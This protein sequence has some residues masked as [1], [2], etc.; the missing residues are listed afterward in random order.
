MWILGRVTELVNAIA[1]EIWNLLS[2]LLQGRRYLVKW[3]KFE[4]RII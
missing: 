2:I 4:N 1:I 3:R